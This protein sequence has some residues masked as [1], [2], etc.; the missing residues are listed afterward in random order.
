MKIGLLNISFSPELKGKVRSRILRL[1]LAD[2]DVEKSIRHRLI[3]YYVTDIGI[4]AGQYICE[5]TRSLKKH[6][7]TPTVVFYSLK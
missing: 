2:G 1:L 3:D 6:Y 7:K 4:V 5:K